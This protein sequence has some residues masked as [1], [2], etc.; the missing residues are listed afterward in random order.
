MGK[1]MIKYLFVLIFIG[2]SS[3][4]FRKTVICQ[5]PLLPDME[6]S[7][8]GDPFVAMGAGRIHPEDS[9]LERAYLANLDTPTFLS[10]VN[11]AGNYVK[12]PFDK[13]NETPI[14]IIF[15]TDNS[16]HHLN[17][18]SLTGILVF[19]LD[20]VKGRM[21]SLLFKKE[22]GKVFSEIEVFNNSGYYFVFNDLF[23]ISPFVFDGANWAYFSLDHKPAV[24]GPR[25]YMFL[26]RSLFYK[27]LR[28][29]GK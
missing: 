10:M 25:R 2:S 21:H 14:G 29:Y 13:K 23:S 24:T 5:R 12:I 17:S 1:I 9:L 26:T 16:I 28:K 3:C 19:M 8:N 4:I 7:I 6:F 15:Y 20:T 22:S 11:I 27:P 18:D